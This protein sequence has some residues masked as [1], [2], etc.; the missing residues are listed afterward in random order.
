MNLRKYCARVAISV[1][2]ACFFVQPASAQ[3]Y[4]NLITEDYLREI[5]VFGPSDSMKYNE[6]EEK[7]YTTCEYVWGVP[8]DMDATLAQNGL[9]PKGDAVTAIYAQTTS[10]DFW[11]RVLSSYSDAV[12]VP[13]IGVLAVWSETRS[14]LSLI[15]A[16]HLIIHVNV[17]KSG[18]EDAQAMALTIAN[19]ILDNL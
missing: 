16:D 17:R 19:H 1:Q 12:D 7:S 5:F 8:S 15:N 13:G 14:Q 6:C 11:P 18:A 10:L 3:D 4:L 9:S 2:L